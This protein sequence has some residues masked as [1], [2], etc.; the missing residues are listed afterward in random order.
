MFYIL[1][2]TASFPSQYGLGPRVNKPTWPLV[3]WSLLCDQRFYTVQMA[4]VSNGGHK[5]PVSS[6][7]TNCF[8]AILLFHAA[9]QPKWPR[10]L[11]DTWILFH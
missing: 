7:V 3:P 5:H 8:S 9:L 2:S 1:T 10:G 6:A 4:E 11:V